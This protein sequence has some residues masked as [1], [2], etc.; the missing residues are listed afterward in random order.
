MRK[1]KELL[2][3]RLNEDQINKIMYSIGFRYYNIFKKYKDKKKIIHIL[4]PL[5]GNMGDQAIV[6][7]TNKYLRDNLVIMK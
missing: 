6:Y 5:H 7:A 1:I 4:T 2:I 3:R